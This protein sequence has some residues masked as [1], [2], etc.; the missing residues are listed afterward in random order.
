MTKR[1]QFSGYGENPTLR[2]KRE[3]NGASESV[4]NLSENAVECSLA[5]QKAWERRG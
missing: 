3:R 2:L 5:V 1:D 4:N